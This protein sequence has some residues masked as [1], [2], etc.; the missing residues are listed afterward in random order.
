[1]RALPA[2]P[3]NTGV[4]AAGV[5]AAWLPGASAAG[6][7]AA[8]LPTAGRTV[9]TAVLPVEQRL[10][11]PGQCHQ[12]RRAE[13]CGHESDNMRIECHGLWFS[14]VFTALKPRAAARVGAR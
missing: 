14:T 2:C 1:M 6:A 5:A 3:P 12:Q 7:A 4:S 13:R 10:L 8:E 9:S 11:D